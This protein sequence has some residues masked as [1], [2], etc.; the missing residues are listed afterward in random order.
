LLYVPNYQLNI[1][2]LTISKGIDPGVRFTLVLDAWTS[3]NCIAFLA[4]VLQLINN[5]GILGE[6]LPIPLAIIHLT[7][8]FSLLEELLIDFCELQGAHSGENMA[9]AVYETLKLYD[10]QDKAGVVF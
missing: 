7:D 3:S 1:T 8:W 9:N 6:S 4:I 5:D 2:F 10:I